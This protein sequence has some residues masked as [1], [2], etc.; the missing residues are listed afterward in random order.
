MKDLTSVAY[1]PRFAFMSELSIILQISPGA[2]LLGGEKTS[3][4]SVSCPACDWLD[5]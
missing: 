2:Y 3:L 1:L 4:G 5:L